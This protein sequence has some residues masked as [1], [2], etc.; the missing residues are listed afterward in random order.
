ME[1]E[2]IQLRLFTFTRYTYRPVLVTNLELTPPA[3]W[4]FYCD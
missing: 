4:R 1:L 2:E 3:V